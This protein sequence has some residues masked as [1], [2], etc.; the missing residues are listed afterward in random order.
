MNT[1]S[2]QNESPGYSKY[3]PD[4]RERVRP[5]YVLFREFEGL[6]ER[7][8]ENILSPALSCWEC[9]GGGRVAACPAALVAALPLGR[10]SRECLHLSATGL[11]ALILLRMG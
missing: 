5:V 9:T 7:G 1:G 8:C 6:G 11:R 4:L 2:I 3:R 10:R